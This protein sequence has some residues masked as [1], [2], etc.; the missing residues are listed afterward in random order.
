[1]G[2]TIVPP[3]RD[4]ARGPSAVLAGESSK[5]VRH[6]VV[7]GFDEHRID[8]TEADRRGGTDGLGDMNGKERERDEFVTEKQ[9]TR[10]ELASVNY[11]RNVAR[12]TKPAVR[13]I[14]ANDRDEETHEQALRDMAAR[15]RAG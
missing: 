13:F 12:S 1:V 6:R 14:F 11:D 3:T 7:V 2:A 8:L 4:R 9:W 15:R 10:P 5:V